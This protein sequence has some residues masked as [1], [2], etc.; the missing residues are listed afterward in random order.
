MYQYLVSIQI[1][2]FNF[3][4]L[5]ALLYYQALKMKPVLLPAKISDNKWEYIILTYSV[6]I[7]HIVNVERSWLWLPKSGNQLPLWCSPRY[8]RIGKTLPLNCEF[9]TFS[10]SF[11][12]CSYSDRADI[13]Q[14]WTVQM[15][16]MLHFARKPTCAE[17]SMSFGRRSRL[18][19]SLFRKS[20]RLPREQ[21]K[22]FTEILDTLFSLGLSFHKVFYDF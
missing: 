13:S 12:L 5:M 1:Y 11:S 10:S 3:W 2:V 21:T 9:C 16:G 20:S 7:K 15:S 17:K 14:S 22:R 19:V 4:L 18:P 8:Q 6:M